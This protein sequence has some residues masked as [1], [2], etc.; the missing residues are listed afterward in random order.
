LGGFLEIPA[1]C[2]SFF[3]EA[4]DSGMSGPFRPEVSWKA[5]MS[6]QPYR[7]NDLQALHLYCTPGLKGH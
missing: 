2:R 5:G 7:Y 1:A 6:L 4:R 3:K